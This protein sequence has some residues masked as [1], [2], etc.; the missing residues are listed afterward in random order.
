MTGMNACI[1]ML[2]RLLGWRRFQSII[3]WVMCFSG[4]PGNGWQVGEG[5]VPV[6]LCDA[7]F[8]A[9]TSGQK[10]DALI[11]VKWKCMRFFHFTISTILQSWL[12]W[13]FIGVIEKSWHDI[14]GS[15]RTSKLLVWDAVFP[16]KYVHSSV[17]LLD[18][19]TKVGDVTGG[20]ESKRS[21]TLTII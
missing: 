5:S 12:A 14:R 1:H 21:D 16:D 6:L 20:T 2:A 18:P 17:V 15:W 7:Q 4:W 10:E 19:F 13:L 8:G 3:I 9:T 11:S